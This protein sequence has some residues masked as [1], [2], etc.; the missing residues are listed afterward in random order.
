MEPHAS[1]PSPSREAGKEFPDQNLQGKIWEVRKIRFWKMGNGSR[2]AE[3]S[4][5]RAMPCLKASQC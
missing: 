1:I 5:A 2:M 4:K 3:G